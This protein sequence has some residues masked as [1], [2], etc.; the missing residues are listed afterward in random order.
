MVCSGRKSLRGLSVFPW[1]PRRSL[2]KCH[3]STEQ[4]AIFSVGSVPFSGSYFM[5]HRCS[6]LTLL[7]PVSVF[8]GSSQSPHVIFYSDAANP[9]PWRPGIS[10]LNPSEGQFCTAAPISASSVE[11]TPSSPLQRWQEAPGTLHL[12]GHMWSTVPIWK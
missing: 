6:L 7:A 9:T 12:Q 4:V 11:V 10:S 2:F 5:S 1:P 3:L 8:R